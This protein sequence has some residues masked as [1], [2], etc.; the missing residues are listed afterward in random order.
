MDVIVVFFAFVL[1]VL[2]QRVY[3]ARF[4]GFAK[5]GESWEWS[6]NKLYRVIH[7]IYCELCPRRLYCERYKKEISKWPKTQVCK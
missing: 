2:V 1:G 7:R 4:K 5:L 3:S 6:D